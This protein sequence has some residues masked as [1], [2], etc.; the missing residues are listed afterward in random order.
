[1]LLFQLLALFAKFKN[2]IIANN[3]ALKSALAN[4]DTYVHFL[5]IM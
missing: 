5:N 2:Q 3:T 1:M 4:N